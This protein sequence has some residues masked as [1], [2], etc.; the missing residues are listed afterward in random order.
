MFEKKSYDNNQ[1]Q[2]KDIEHRRQLPSPGNVTNHLNTPVRNQNVENSSQPK[3]CL[4]CKQLG[5]EIL[6]ALIGDQEVN[7]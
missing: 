3:E 6:L 2:N 1:G 7:L 5:D 4:R